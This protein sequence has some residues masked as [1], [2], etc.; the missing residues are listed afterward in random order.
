MDIFNNSVDGRRK[1]TISHIQSS[2]KTILYDT[3][4]LQ[5]EIVS[6]KNNISTLQERIKSLEDSI[7]QNSKSLLD[8]ESRISEL[9]GYYSEAATLIGITRE[10]VI[11]VFETISHITK[12]FEENSLSDHSLFIAQL[13]TR[14]QTVE[15]SYIKKKS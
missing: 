1:N 8:S 3:K 4:L 9:F 14:L 15:D 11:R 7:R 6:L 2:N 12:E 10:D 13:H 5:S